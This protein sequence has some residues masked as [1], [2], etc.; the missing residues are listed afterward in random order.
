LTKVDHFLQTYQYN[1]LFGNIT[2][3]SNNNDYVSIKT[4]I[5]KKLEDID[6]SAYSQADY[7][8]LQIEKILELEMHK[9]T[10]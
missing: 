1:E 7:R 6:K 3:N 8:E 4:T 10:K 2:K 9:Q 5:D